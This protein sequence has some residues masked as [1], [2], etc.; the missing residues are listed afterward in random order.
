VIEGHRRL[1]AAIE[2]GLAE[3]PCD[4]AADRADDEPGQFLD[5]YAANHHR[6]D[7]TTLEEADALFAASAAGASKTRIRKATGLEAHV[8]GG[9]PATILVGL[10]DSRVRETRDRV[11]AAMVNSHLGWPVRK[12]T[13][14]LS[15]ASLPKQ[16]SGHDL[17][18]AVA[19]LAA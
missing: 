15:P 18:I 17:A 6:K 13:V 10:P 19:I 11:R 2:A 8:G 9:L 1:A 3:V 4:I 7:L 5:M 16:G 12:I 14:G